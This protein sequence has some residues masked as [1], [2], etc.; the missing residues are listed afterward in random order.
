MVTSRSRGGT[1]NT[2]RKDF[3]LRQKQ[4]L[5]RSLCRVPKLPRGPKHDLGWKDL[6][7]NTKQFNDNAF[8]IHVMNFAKLYSK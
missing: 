4:S 3:F 8:E 2:D 7:S 1:L 5:M 6:L